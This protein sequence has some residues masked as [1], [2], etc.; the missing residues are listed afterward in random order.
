MMSSCLLVSI[1]ASFWIRGVSLSKDKQ[2]SQ[3][4][5]NLLMK[6]DGEVKMSFSHQ[7]QLYDTVLWYRRSSG[8]TSL[9]LIAYVRYESPYVELPFQSHFEVSGDGEK[10]AHLLIK[11]LRHPEH[12]G[13]Y[14]GAAWRHSHKNRDAFVQKL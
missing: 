2:V 1:I 14:F 10:E 4:P 8:N 9:E 12:S 3:T 6:A 5:S 13:E 11:N 7:I